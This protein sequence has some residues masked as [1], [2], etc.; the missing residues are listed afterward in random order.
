MLW[1]SSDKELPRL[2]CLF[3]E[4]L[5]NRDGLKNRKTKSG[6]VLLWNKDKASL[7]CVSVVEV[8][9]HKKSNFYTI[10][11]K[12]ALEH[13]F[14]AQWWN[15]SDKAV[16]KT[17]FVILSRKIRKSANCCSSCIP[18]Q[19]PSHSKLRTG[20]WLPCLSEGEICCGFKVSL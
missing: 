9:G 18:T 2:L 6:W 8:D 3:V 20:V 19:T 4:Q 1:G 7:R 10:L 13:G 14:G 5:F 17:I 16:F 11:K 15:Y 12:K